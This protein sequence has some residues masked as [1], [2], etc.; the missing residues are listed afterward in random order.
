[1]GDEEVQLFMLGAV[2]LYGSYAPGDNSED[3]DLD[4]L[5]V[6]DDFQ[7]RPAEV[8]RV[9]VLFGD[10]SLDYEIIVSPMFVRENEWKTNKLPLLRGSCPEQVAK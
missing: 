4:V 1:M 3:S 6:L 8:C 7:R 10:L 5:V 2:Y 9:S